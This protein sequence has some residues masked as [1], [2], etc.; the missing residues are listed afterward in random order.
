M[1]RTDKY[2]LIA[3]GTGFATSF[4]L[5]KYLEKSGPDVSVLVLERGELHK[6]SERLAVE[7]GLKN[8]YD[9]P[10]KDGFDTIENATPEK[11]WIFDPSFGGSSNCW[12]GCTPRPLPSDFEMKTRFGVGE[13][14]PMSYDDLEAYLTE[15]EAIMNIAGPEDTP[16]PMSRKYPL[17]THQFNE[18][19]KLLRKKY[20]NLHIS[21]PTARAS[22]VVDGRGQCCV[23]ACCNLCPVNAKFTIENSMMGLFSDPRVSL[24][25]GAQV[26]SLVAQNN[27]IKKV[28]YRKDNKDVEVEGELVAIGTNPIFNA[29]ILLNSGDSHPMTGR[30]LTEQVS[31]S[32]KLFLKD[33]DNTG[34]S[35]VVSANGYMLYD[36]DH[37]RE[38]SAVLLESFNGSSIMR[39]ERGKWKQIAEFR[40]IVED[41]P[42]LDNRVVP[43]DD[44]LKPKVIFNNYT[45][46]ALKA[47]SNIENQLEDLFEGIPYEKIELESGTNKTE[48]HI[49]SSTMM[50][51][52]PEKGVIDRN[53]VHH[54]WRNLF[55]LGS[56]AFPTI[57]PVNPTI[58]LSALSLFA[59][60]KYFSKSVSV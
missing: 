53:L 16:Y 41:L 29:H 45:D 15:A 17:P 24:I 37:R 52:D 6:H 46:Y 51:D 5:K 30:G 9:L 21:Q 39:I 36:G 27:V 50:N 35:T 42:D 43:S 48:A 31:R 56:G 25:T 54:K 14:W 12:W 47:L 28:A 7:T 57:S 8:D 40:L 3:V 20:G 19:D 38:R 33:L 22:R 11:P 1:A 18:V 32:C 58:I 60:D 34:A 23:S 44:L 26:Y 4:F 13:D 55:V 59:A 10:K 2:S 49:Y